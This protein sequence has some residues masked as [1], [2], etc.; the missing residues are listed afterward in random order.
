MVP[1]SQSLVGR[2]HFSSR[3]S[4]GAGEL[5][6]FHRSGGDG[7]QLI[8]K[9]TDQKDLGEPAFSPDGKSVYFSQD[10]TA[11]TTFE[12]NKDPNTEI[13][14][15]MRLDLERRELDKIAGGPGG[16]IR[17][18]PSPDGKSLAFIRRVRGKSLLFVSELKSG[19][20]TPLYDALDRDLME[21]WA[22]HGVY[23]TMAWTP[24]SKSIVF[25]AQGAL[26][27]LDVA[28]KKA[29]RIPFHVK[30]ARRVAEAVRFAQ[31]VAPKQFDV[32]MTRW[33]QASP[34][35]DKV[36]F[37]ALGHL[38]IAALPGGV[39][40]RLTAQTEH[41]EAWPS[42]T[43][44]GQSIVY[45]TWHDEQLSSIRLVSAS[46]GEGKVLT[47]R[48]GHYISPVVSPDGKSLVYQAVGGGVLVSSLYSQERG[49][50]VQPMAGGSA[51][52]ISKDGSDPHFAGSS[53]RVYFMTVAQDGKEDVRALKSIGLDASEE[54]THLTSDEASEYRVSPDGKW[55]AFRENFHVFLMPFPT[56]AKAAVASPETKALPVAK[57]TRDA[58]EAIHFSGDSKSLHWSLGPTL[59]TRALKDAFKFIEGSP[60]KLPSPP[61]TGVDLK[62]SAVT[63]FAPGEVALVGARLITMK[64][65][66]V[67]EDGTVLVR[68]GRIA[69]I[70][71]RASVVIPKSAKTIDVAGKTIIPG[72]ID[73]HWHGALGEAGFVP[74]QNYQ[75]LSSL[76][77][78]VTTIHD[79]SNDT[80]GFFAAAEQQRTGAIL[81]PRLFST[82]TILYGAQ[83]WFRAQI[84]SLEDAR[85]HLRRLKAVGAF[86]VKSYNQPRR[87]QRQRVIQAARELRMMV[88]PEGGSLLQHNLT[89]IVDG[90]TGIEHAIPV[91][92]V[93]EDVLQLW[94]GTRVGYTPTLGVAYGGLRGENYW[95]MATDVWKDERLSAFVP[96]KFLDARARR[97]VKV[98][99][100]ELNHIAAAQVATKLQSRGVEVQLGAHGQ[101][102]GL[103][104]H[105]ELAMFGQGGMTPI[106]A[107][108][109]GTID[110]ARYLGLD[111]DVGSLEPGKLAD[112]VVLDKNPLEK[113]EN[114]HEVRFTMLAGRLYS[115]ASLDEI[116][117][118]P[119]KRAPLYFE[120][121][122]E[123]VW[124]G[125]VQTNQCGGH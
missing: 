15:V 90:H 93:Y 79:P 17:P 69:A 123:D 60:L 50:Y 10:V 113:I 74:Q 105:W 16:A 39:P 18:T 108:R 43:A 38:W 120:R 47:A 97:R 82:G 115:A 45:S 54:R 66:Q 96:R 89:Q 98:P 64:G 58:G 25:W 73:V 56:G 109:A 121:L 106:N 87:D 23:P 110:G 30:S 117:P 5:W 71:P 37:E 84:E 124:P 46:G 122:G 68:D 4:L 11:G 107:L 34:K 67:I 44:D 100:E 61:V 77:F 65:E 7:V 14:A 2:K 9:P 8:E 114:S 80:D 94:S 36:V 33:V 13:Y 75:L 59:F 22:I 104:A 40:K 26:W 88:V 102:E 6:L 20:E 92:K 32:K 83:G 24:D 72:L 21:T 51:R 49:L 103:A 111:N 48:P 119:R 112:L 1:D 29:S 70:G 99:D 12:Y 41:S 118:R 42:F 52:R 85:T 3:R 55:L 95:Y 19:R 91:A 86:S 101:R 76:S 78:G 28:S 35:G 27:R 57:L 81:G 125:Q 62:V 31:V 116:W 53:D 63:D